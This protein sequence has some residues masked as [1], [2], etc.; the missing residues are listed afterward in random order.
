MSHFLVFHWLRSF[1][2]PLNPPQFQVLS[3][4]HWRSDS[5]CW[6]HLAGKVSNAN[7][8]WLVWILG[9]DSHS[10]QQL[11]SASF[12]EETREVAKS[13]GEGRRAMLNDSG[14]TCK[15][16]LVQILNKMSPFISPHIT[17]YIFHCLLV[18]KNVNF[19]FL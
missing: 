4:S 2:G 17:T 14:V 7:E 15:L 13:C 12:Q 5:F 11:K 16:S 10:Q 3:D 9:S 6:P 19:A 1:Q 8:H 18:I